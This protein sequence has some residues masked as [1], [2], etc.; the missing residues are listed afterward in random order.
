MDKHSTLVHQLWFKYHAKIKFKLYLCSMLEY[1]I[2]Y[3]ELYKNFDKKSCFLNEDLCL[4]TCNI[5]L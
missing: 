4:I 2:N 1:Y 5:Y 3:I